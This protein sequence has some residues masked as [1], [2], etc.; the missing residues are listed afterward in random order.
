MEGFIEYLSCNYK[1]AVEIGIGLYPRVALALEARGLQVTATDLQ[2]EFMGVPVEFD[3]VR[4]PRLD[5]YEGA[6]VIYAVRPPLEL[7]PSLKVLANT[8]AVDLVIKPLADEP[9]D[10]LLINHGGSFFYLFPAKKRIFPRP[11]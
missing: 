10:G 4:A 8:L 5:L 7:L 6:Q 1:M 2:P 11:S 3:D 9:A